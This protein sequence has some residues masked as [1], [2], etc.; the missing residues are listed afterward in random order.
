M[1]VFSYVVFV[2]NQNDRVAL[3]VKLIQETHDL[4]RS[5]RV[6]VSRGLIGQNDRRV[7]D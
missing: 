3:V 1:S 7:V 6:E 2:R 5:L 4:V